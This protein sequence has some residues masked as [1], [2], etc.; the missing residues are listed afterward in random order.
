MEKIRISK[1]LS[2]RKVC[3]RRE[4]EKFIDEGQVFLNGILVTEQGTKAY[5]T[6]RIEIGQSAKKERDQKVTIMLHKPLGIVSNLP[7]PGYTEASELIIEENH[8]QWDKRPF[9][10]I[11]GPLNVVGRLDVNSKGLL[12]LTQDG[13]VAKQII[14]PDSIVEKEYIVRFEG[15]L[16]E[17]QLD[18][19]REGITLDGKRLK[20]AGVE[21]KDASTLR[22]ILIEGKKRQL[23]RMC[24]VVGITV[25]SLKRVRIGSLQLGE[26]P[27]GKWRYVDLSE[28]KLKST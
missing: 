25:T 10:E 7:E 18:F 24:E 4:A 3:S 26:L 15:D 5:P 17:R 14:G 9:Q 28:F 8:W 19:F 13:R 22:V 6:D 11:V 27:S 21:R 20:R 16:S 12:L 2:E 1:L 23:R